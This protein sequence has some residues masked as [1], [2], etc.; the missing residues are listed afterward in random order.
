MRQICTESD[1]FCVDPKSTTEIQGIANV[2]RRVFYPEQHKYINMLEVI[3]HKMPSLFPGFNYEIVESSELPDR[4]AEMIPS[5]QCIRIRDSVYLEAGRNDGRS[6]F[7]LAHE[8]GHYILHLKQP[9]AF[10]SPAK[11]GSI[12]YYRHSE[13]QANT[14]ARN[15]LA[16]LSLAKGLDIPAIVAVFEV[17]NEVAT[18][19][20]REASEMFEPLINGTKAFCQ[21]ALPGFE[22]LC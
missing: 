18:I 11:S 5:K 9:L 8:V 10:G 7:T 19:I 20:H 3:E 15:F 21:C 22:G 16:P 12:P 4:E 6:R 2:V 13:W 14:F 1:G 17:S